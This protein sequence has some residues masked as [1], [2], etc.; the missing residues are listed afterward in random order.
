MP[1]TVV[2]DYPAVVEFIDTE[3]NPAITASVGPLV[4]RSAKARALVRTGNLRD[5]I[6]WS[7]RTDNGTGFT[8]IHAIFYDLFQERPARQIAHATRALEDALQDIPPVLL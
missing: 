3:V 7:E 5:S 1:A 2:M 4:T 8:E 6:D